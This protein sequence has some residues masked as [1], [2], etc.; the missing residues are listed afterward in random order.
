MSRSDLPVVR[1]PDVIKQMVVGVMILPGHRIMAGMGARVAAP[2]FRGAE[3]REYIHEKKV[4][5]RNLRNRRFDRSYGTYYLHSHDG[6]LARGDDGDGRCAPDVTS[7]GAVSVG[8]EI[9]QSAEQATARPGFHPRRLE[10]K[11]YDQIYRLNR[12]PS[13]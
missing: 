12:S 7:K 11:Y 4:P 3:R 9:L 8:M 13:D 1:R 5:L 6:L 2:L 10:V